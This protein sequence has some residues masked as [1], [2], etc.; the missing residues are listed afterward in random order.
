MKL[1][2]AVIPACLFFS[3]NVFAT[4]VGGCFSNDTD[5]SEWLSKTI[6]FS[7]PL[8][9]DYN[10]SSWD[11]I[12]QFYFDFDADNVLNPRSFSVE[13]DL[14]NPLTEHQSIT[15]RLEGHS[16]ANGGSLN[17]G[18]RFYMNLNNVIYFDKLEEGNIHLGL[19]RTG[20]SEIV[21]L[22]SL[23]AKFCGIRVIEGQTA[24]VDAT[25]HALGSTDNYAKPFSVEPEVTYVLTVDGAASDG[26]NRKLGGVAY[27][28]DSGRPFPLFFKQVVADFTLR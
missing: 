8:V 22:H 28:A 4:E 18:N 11:D 5:G 25:K 12:H 27:S 23:T 6:S 13:G 3:A 21:K 7:T 20:S 1:I 9:I 2:E 10:S 26:M 24:F 19:G 16:S 15:G 17:P 14:V